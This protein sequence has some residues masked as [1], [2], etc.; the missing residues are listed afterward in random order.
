MMKYSGELGLM[1]R[2]RTDSKPCP[3]INK[4]VLSVFKS[5]GGIAYRRYY[6]ERK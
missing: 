4:L 2:Y 3:Q 5:T 1:R 6:K